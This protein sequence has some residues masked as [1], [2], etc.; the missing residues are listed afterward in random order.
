[1]ESEICNS[2]RR[3]I[4]RQSKKSLISLSI[5]PNVTI[6]KE[7][8]DGNVSHIH[9]CTHKS[10]RV[11]LFMQ[12]LSMPTARIAS[13]CTREELKHNKINLLTSLGA[14]KPLE[15]CLVGFPH[16]CHISLLGQAIWAMMK[17]VAKRR[18]DISL[19]RQAA[20]RREGERSW[21]S[22]VTI[23]ALP[24]PRLSS[25]TSETVREEPAIS[26]RWTGW[27][28][29]ITSWSSRLQEIYQSF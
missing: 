28:R 27:V 1:M 26:C 14:P 15:W 18:E 7:P 3:S 12:I 20:E 11:L 19:P 5:S 16:T 29:E 2:P 4:V 22:R 21:L 8:H 10:S 25:H 9:Q 6:T 17:A 13:P 24:Y 23:D